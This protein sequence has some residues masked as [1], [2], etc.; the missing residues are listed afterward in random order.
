MSKY[1]VY[2]CASVRLTDTDTPG[3]LGLIIVDDY[4]RDYYINSYGSK[5]RS[6]YRL[7]LNGLYLALQE[8]P[9]HSEVLVRSTD[10]N[11]VRFANDVDGK[12]DGANSD[13]KQAI[14]ALR[15]QLKSELISCMDSRMAEVKEMAQ[16][17]MR[18]V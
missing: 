3:G 7:M 11:V 2:V 5:G 12:S 1:T 4:D 8:I 9:I 10:V 14:K 15:F 16:I 17:R 18:N 13:V 6:P